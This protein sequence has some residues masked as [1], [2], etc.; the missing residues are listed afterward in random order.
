[1]ERTIIFFFFTIRI[2]NPTRLPTALPSNSPTQ[3]RE[4]LLFFLQ[5]ITLKIGTVQFYFVVYLI[6]YSLII[7]TLPSF[8]ETNNIVTI[9]FS[10]QKSNIV[11]YQGTAY[12]FALFHHAFVPAEN[13]ASI[14][15]TLT[16]IFFYYYPPFSESY[17]VTL[18]FTLKESSV[19]F[20]V[21]YT[22]KVSFLAQLEMSCCCN[23]VLCVCLLLILSVYS[24]FG[25]FA[26]F[27]YL[28]SFTESRIFF[29]HSLALEDVKLIAID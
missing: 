9:K 23:F 7:R 1:M 18:S 29:T 26:T 22:G 5:N 10:L 13:A 28:L 20:W 6:I 2:Q 8:S 4:T 19:D 21:T 11:S 14:V 27:S 25:V 3:V 12:S 17:I 24:T 15:W 16:H